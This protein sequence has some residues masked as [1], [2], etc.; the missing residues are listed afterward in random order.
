MVVS[1]QHVDRRLG[2]PVVEVSKRAQSTLDLGLHPWAHCQSPLL[3]CSHL[4]SFLVLPSHIKYSIENLFPV[5]LQVVYN[6]VTAYATEDE[7]CIYLVPH[8]DPQG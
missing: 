1:R 2:S 5:S 8:T 4:H 3:C 7:K 6:E